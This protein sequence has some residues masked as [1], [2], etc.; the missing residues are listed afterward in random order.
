MEADDSIR[1][2]SG[3]VCCLRELGDGKL[4]LVLDDLSNKSKT[5]SGPWEHIVVFTWQDFPEQEIMELKVSEK[6]LA[7]F[8]FNVLARLV[9]LRKRPMTK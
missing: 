5:T 3:V 1:S 4:R 2:D 8:G 9:A 7:E 6:K